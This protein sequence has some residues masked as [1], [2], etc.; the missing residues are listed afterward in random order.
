MNSPINE[1]AN[2]ARLREP[3]AQRFDFASLVFDLHEELANLRTET[4]PNSHGHRQKALFKHSDR[5]IALFAFEPG[6]SLPEHSTNGTVTIEVI[7]GEL[8]VTVGG[9]QKSLGSGQL[10]VLAPGTR[11]AVS[12]RVQAGFLLQ[13]SLVP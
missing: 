13:V 4:S 11:H 10:L 1:D 3:P 2:E 9:D 7:E 5:T 8:R 12:A 6:G